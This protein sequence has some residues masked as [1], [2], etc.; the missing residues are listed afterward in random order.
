L[1][2]AEVDYREWTMKEIWNLI[3]QNGEAADPRDIPFVVRK[4]G[5]RTNFVAEGYVHHPDIP[6]WL[7]AQGKLIREQDV[8][9]VVDDEA[10]AALLT[11]EFSDFDN[12]F[13]FSNDED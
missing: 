12:E 6:E 2:P 13:D 3:T 1:D 5:S 8:E 4:P 7:E 10:E 11:S 9:D